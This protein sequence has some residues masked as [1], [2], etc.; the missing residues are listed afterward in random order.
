MIVLTIVIDHETGKITKMVSSQRESPRE[1]EYAEMMKKLF[2]AAFD[3][4][5]QT[6]LA[7]IAKKKPA[8]KKKEKK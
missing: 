7:K 3:P 4:Q 6:V 2:D 1:R 8:S 5:A